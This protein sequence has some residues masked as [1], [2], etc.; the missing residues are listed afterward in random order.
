MKI[1]PVCCTN[2]RVMKRVSYSY[3]D[4]YAQVGQFLYKRGEDGLY[5]VDSYNKGKDHAT[6][7]T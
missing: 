7:R 3:R 4:E 6:V 2:G 5:R 1:I